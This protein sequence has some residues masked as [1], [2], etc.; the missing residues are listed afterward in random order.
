MLYF[1]TVSGLVGQRSKVIKYYTQAEGALVNGYFAQF[2]E[3]TVQ[4][5][6][7]VRRSKFIL[8]PIE[9]QGLTLWLSE[10]HRLCNNL[11][12]CREP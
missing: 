11:R 8:F 9:H 7:P 2:R 5:W 12:P 1:K 3:R 6:Q 4:S 10:T